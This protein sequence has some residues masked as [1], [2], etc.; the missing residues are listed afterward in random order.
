[1]SFGDDTLDP[2]NYDYFSERNKIAREVD[3]SWYNEIAKRL[4]Q[5]KVQSFCGA[6]A[7][8][9]WLFNHVTID[10]ASAELAEKLKKLEKECSTS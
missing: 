9:R 5:I 10:P 1:M 6:E 8:I 3:R 7:T 4:P 2:A